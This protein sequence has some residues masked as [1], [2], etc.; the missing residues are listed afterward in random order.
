M[1]KI[2]GFNWDHSNTG[3]NWEKHRIANTDAEEVFFNYPR[4][5]YP[6]KSESSGGKKRFYLFGK[7]NTGRR[8]FVVFTVRGNLL[9][10]IS[11]RD[12]SKKER[13][14]YDERIK[15]NPEIQNRR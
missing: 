6:G 15:K 11:A 7:T 8:L 2:E 14:R 4:F 1:V 5:V 9:R 10:V 3:I 13:R 12:M